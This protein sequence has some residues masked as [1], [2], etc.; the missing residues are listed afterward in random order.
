MIRVASQKV[1]FGFGL[2]TGVG[3]VTALRAHAMQADRAGLDLV[4]L[5]DHPYFADRLDAYAALGIVLGR[6]TRITGAV[7][8]TNLPSL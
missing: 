1:L 4:S 2:E 8:V 5:S 7:N 3:E 6:T